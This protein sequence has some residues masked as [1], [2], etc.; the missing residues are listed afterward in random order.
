MA[1]FFGFLFL[2]ALAVWVGSIVFFSFVA[3]PSVYG[4]V[5]EQAAVRAM[6]PMAR[7]YL[8]IGWIC[9]AL[10]M[11][12]ALF[13]PP[14]GGLYSTT[15]LVLVAVMFLL[16]LY[17]VFGPGGRVREAAAAVESAGDEDLP[18]DALAAF[19]E[20]EETTKTLNGALLLL[21]LVVVFITAFYA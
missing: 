2:S 18:K 3:A 10:A 5:P 8:R 14:V 19:G 4:A 11:A 7:A 21:G 9:G 6:V 20:F 12:S 16:A 13:L 15:R 1:A 17:L